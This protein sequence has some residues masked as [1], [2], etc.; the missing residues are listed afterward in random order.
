MAEQSPKTAK[1]KVRSKAKSGLGEAI[2]ETTLDLAAQEGWHDLRLSQ[3]AARIMPPLWRLWQPAV[4]GVLFMAGQLCVLHARIPRHP[5]AWRAE[6]ETAI[7]SAPSAIA[8]AKSAGVRS[9]PVITSVVSW[10]IESR[11]LRAR[12]SA[13]IVGTEMLSRKRVGAAPVA[14]PRPSRMM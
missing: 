5:I 1:A 3:V 4:I 14:P 2:L 9:P 12:A 6:F 10:E 8:L 13:G 7:A 11:C